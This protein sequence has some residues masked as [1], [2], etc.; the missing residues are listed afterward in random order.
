MRDS[1]KGTSMYNVKF[2]FTVHS[3]Y[4]IK[5]ADKVVVFENVSQILTFE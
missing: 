3:E 4:E 2:E 1:D 5:D